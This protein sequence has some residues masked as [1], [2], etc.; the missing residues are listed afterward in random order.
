MAVQ[1]RDHKVTMGYLPDHELYQVEKP[2][3]SNVPFF[4]IPGAKQHNI[5]TAY[6][7]GIPVTDIR[8]NEDAISLDKQG[9]EIRRRTELFEE[10]LFA[11]EEWIKRQYCPQTETF[12]KRELGATQVVCFD[13]TV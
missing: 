10:H 6:Y 4:H 11:D 3:F 9:F 7:E 2:F 13:H 5:K 1:S 8:D 12:L